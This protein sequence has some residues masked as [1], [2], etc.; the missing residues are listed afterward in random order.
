MRTFTKLRSFFAMEASVNERIGKLEEDC[1]KVF[2]IVFERLDSID[3]QIAPILPAH[4]TKI[5]LKK[6]EQT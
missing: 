6:K 4:R 2:K 3:K 1:T 5:G